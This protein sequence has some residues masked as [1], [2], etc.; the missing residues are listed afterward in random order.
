MPRPV[1]DL[2]KCKSEAK[3]LLAA[4]QSEEAAASRATAERFHTIEPWR[5]RSLE[6][7]IAHR[8]DVQLKHAQAVVAR[9]HKFIDWKSLKNAADVVWYPAGGSAFLNAWFAHY[10]DARTCLDKHG[11]YL[12]TYRGQYFVCE[13]GFIRSLGLDPNDARWD[14]I[15]RDI[16]HPVNRRAGDEL[17]ALAET[18]AKQAQPMLKAPDPARWPGWMR[19]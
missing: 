7:I 17:R 15:G 14:E 13:A 2:R 8:D 4:L 10:A 1:P 11:G 16:A 6:E 9:E 18:A 3:R 12:L 19:P 5:S